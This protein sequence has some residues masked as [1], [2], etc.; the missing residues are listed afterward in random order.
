MN[1]G[2]GK[3]NVKLQV[4][5]WKE[6]ASCL[7]VTE[8]PRYYERRETLLFTLSISSWMRAAC[9]DKLMWLV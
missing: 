4:I 5:G 8:A 6:G 7:C 9:C 3:T 2:K 1:G